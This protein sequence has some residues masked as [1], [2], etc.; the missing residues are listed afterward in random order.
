MNRQEISR[1]L[2]NMQN[3]AFSEFNISVFAWNNVSP[4]NSSRSSQFEDELRAKKLH[5]ASIER[6]CVYSVQKNHTN[7]NVPSIFSG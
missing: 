5:K 2:E 1:C 7:S 3:G 6:G 4:H